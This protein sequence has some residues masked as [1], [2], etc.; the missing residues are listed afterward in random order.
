MWLSD[1]DNIKSFNLAS[2]RDADLVFLTHASIPRRALTLAAIME[3][4]EAIW[5]SGARWKGIVRRVDGRIRVTE[6]RQRHRVGRKGA[7]CRGAPKSA[8]P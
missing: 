3:E 1:L 5:V 6:I 4:A 7:L 8:T 2:R